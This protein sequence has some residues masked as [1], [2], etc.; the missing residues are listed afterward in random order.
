MEHAK[1]G[2]IVASPDERSL[3][4]LYVACDLFVLATRLRSGKQA[5]GEGFG[6]VLAEAA[7]AGRPVLR[8]RSVARRL[9]SRPGLTGVSAEDESPP[10]SARALAW[11]VAHPE[12][13]TELG[14]NARAWG[15]ARSS[16]RS[17]TVAR[18]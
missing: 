5:S 18:C 7:L 6:I 14:R 1:S 9:L 2:L 13:L 16:T 8:R 3:V 15:R 4:E 11:A 12:R 10:L 17:A